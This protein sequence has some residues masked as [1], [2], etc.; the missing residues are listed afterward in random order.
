[1][2]VEKR[3]KTALALG[4]GAVL[5]A[6]HIGVLK[7]L[8]E[9]DIQIDYIA[10]TSIGAFVAAFYAFGISLKEIEEIALKLKWLDISKISLS[11]YGLLSNNKLGKLIHKYIGNKKIEEAG[12]PLSMI[13]TD[14]S[15][16]DKVI[17]DQGP[18][19]DSV[20]AST[21]IPGIFKPVKIDNMLLVDGGIVENVPFKT[22]R[23]AGA[24][25]VIGVDLNARHT[26]EQPDNILDVIL[27]SFHF[28]FQ[29]QS[30][31]QSEHADLV[32]KPDLS[33]FNRSDINQVERLIE[34]GY[35]DTKEQLRKNADLK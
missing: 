34:K 8:E 5:G 29:Q 2:K 22:C 14:I 1:M 15:N 16:G 23:E 24:S 27:N 26:Y 7:A 19:A 35:S 3:E 11:P 20:M 12:I 10:G 30:D 9:A 21:C 28:V 31:L 25:Y 13:A 6:A 33:A 18:L 32:I 17:L 4:G